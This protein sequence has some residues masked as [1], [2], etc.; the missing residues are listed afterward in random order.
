LNK[1]FSP[2]MHMIKLCVGVSTV[3]ELESYRSER[4]HWWGADYGEGVHVHRTRTRPKRAEEIEGQGSIYW[5]ISGVVRCRQ[6]ILRLAAA[7]DAEG[8][9]CCDIIMA[10]DM[11]K[12]APRP[13]QPFQGWRYLDP[14]D[15]PPD[16]D[17][18]D[19]GQGSEDIAEE[20][21]RLGLL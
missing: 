17:G 9:A 11:I 3:E 7:T 13:K 16:L 20:L 14:K 10:P 1:A 6:P 12:V 5:V 2:M 15:A 18:G 8:R 19:A 4:A 21:A